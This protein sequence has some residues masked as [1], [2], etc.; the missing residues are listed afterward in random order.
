MYRSIV[1]KSGDELVLTIPLE[2]KERLGLEAGASVDSELDQHHL[3]VRPA[4]KYTLQELLDQCDCT[5]PVAEED[6]AWEAM[7]PVGREII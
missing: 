5:L 6:K 7:P 2:M 3:V 1:Q 4:R